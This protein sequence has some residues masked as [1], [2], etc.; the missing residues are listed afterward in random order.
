MALHARELN[1]AEISLAA[2]DEVD[3]VQFI[4]YVKTIPSEQGR[5][6]ELALFC[7]R[8]QEAEQILLQ[9]RLYYRA[10]KMNVRLFKWGRALDIAVSNKKHVDTVIAYRK[11]YLES[12]SREENIAKFQQFAELEIDWV[13][14]KTKIKQDKEAEAMQGRPYEG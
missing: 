11:R 2:I 1:T 4:N 6:A 7:K 14:I 10:I 9:A 5:S 8:P 13:A 3:K 12:V